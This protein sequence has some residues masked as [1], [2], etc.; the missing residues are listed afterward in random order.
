MAQIK[1]NP[2]ATIAQSFN[3]EKKR[4]GT[5]VQIRRRIAQKTDMSSGLEGNM[6]LKS[7]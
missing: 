4:I 7:I 1:E 5:A 6:S 3:F 2:K